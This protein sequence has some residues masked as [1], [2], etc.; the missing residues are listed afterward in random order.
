LADRQPSEDEMLATIAQHPIATHLFPSDVDLASYRANRACYF[1]YRNKQQSTCVNRV[2]TQVFIDLVMHIQKHKNDQRHLDVIVPMTENE[3]AAFANI[4]H[5]DKY[6]G[7]FPQM[8]ITNVELVTAEKQ[9]SFDV[10]SS[11]KSI[12]QRT[13]RI[14]SFFPFPNEVFNA[15]MCFAERD[16]VMCTGDQSFSDVLAIP[17]ALPLYQVMGWKRSLYNAFINLATKVCAEG[18]LT[19]YLK[20]I[21]NRDNDI[22]DDKYATLDQ[23]AAHV[24]THGKVIRQE[25]HVLRKHLFQHHNLYHNLPALLLEYL[26]E[27]QRLDTPVTSLNLTFRAT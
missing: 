23:I 17:N 25:L 21:G 10:T 9:Y 1:G 24:A 4:V 12:K 8:K 27:V 15:L 2:Y 13:L 19:T 5:S 16:L 3:I 22:Y 26:A 7:L 6:S 18:P 11:S 14:L 20:I